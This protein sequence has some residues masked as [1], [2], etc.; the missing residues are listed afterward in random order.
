MQASINRCLSQARKNCEG[1]AAGRA[2]GVIWGG[3]EVGAP[4]V[5]VGVVS[6]GTVGALP[7]LSSMGSYG[8]GGTISSDGMAPTRTV[9]SSASIIFPCSAKILK[10]FVMTCKNIFGFNP[11]SAP[12][13]LR[14]QEVGKPSL[15]TA[16][17]DDKAEGC[18]HDD[19]PRADKLRKG[20]LLRLLPGILTH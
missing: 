13:C 1:Y 8:G 15:N 3:L 12:T 4:L 14:K 11:V 20:W 2:S 19:P 6:T 9:G 17:P 5:S 7:P 16:Q 10:I 18:V